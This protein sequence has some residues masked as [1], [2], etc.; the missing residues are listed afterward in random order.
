MRLVHLILY[1]SLTPSHCSR[2]RLENSLLRTR[3]P[4]E[5]VA[6]IGD[7]T[8]GPGPDITF[9][10]LINTEGPPMTMLVESLGLSPAQEDDRV[11]AMNK[12]MRHLGVSC[13]HSC[14]LPSIHQ[15]TTDT[16]RSYTEVYHHERVYFSY[17]PR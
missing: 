7:P 15:M 14:P 5:S 17:R 11:H 2:V 8:S 1:Q 4:Q 10:E 9:E 13:R 3:Y 16:L 12:V 6:W